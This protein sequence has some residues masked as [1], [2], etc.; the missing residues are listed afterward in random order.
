VDGDRGAR[1]AVADA[2]GDVQ[3]VRGAGGDGRRI[4]SDPDDDRPATGEEIAD[5]MKAW[6][7]LLAEPEDSDFPCAPVVPVHF[8][9]SGEEE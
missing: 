3:C 1:G 7:E 6:L 8:R 2:G 4:V 5:A 9:D